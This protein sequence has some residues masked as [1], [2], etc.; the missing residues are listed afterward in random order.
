MN[1]IQKFREKSVGERRCII[2]SGIA[3]ILCTVLGVLSHFAFEFLGEG[4]LAG[5]IFPVNESIGE[6]LK[7]SFF[8]YLFLI[9]FEYIFYGRRVGNFIFG[10]FLGVLGALA[11]VLGTY[12]TLNGAFGKMPDFVNIIIF[13]IATAL[14]YII[15]FVFYKHDTEKCSIC[16]IIAIIGF[17]AI[18]IMMVAF[19]YY[20]PMIPL[21]LDPQGAGYGYYMI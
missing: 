4:M 2:F 16:R 5:A 21:Y 20:P 3:F 1:I 11:C 12:Y 19:S 13:V 7:L 9:P 8:P 17:M 18:A 6:H 15:P 14:S 10:K